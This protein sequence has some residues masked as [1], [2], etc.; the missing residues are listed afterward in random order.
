MK[1]AIITG[2]ALGA[3]V[4]STGLLTQTANAS[5]AYRTIKTKSYAGTTPAYHA[6]NL[7]KT[8]YM[9]NSTLTKKLHNLK[10]Y[11]R[12]TWYLQK[13]VKLSNG[14]KTGIFYY[15][16][17]NS[18]TASGYVWR[19]YLSKGINNNTDSNPTNTA[20]TI[21]NDTKLQAQMRSLFPGTKH[22]T[23]LDQLAHDDIS[24]NVS[25]DDTLAG[26]ARTA[27]NAPD[28][29]DV[30]VFRVTAGITKPSTLAKVKTV[31]ATN[32]TV[33][34]NDKTVSFNLAN[35][36]N[37]FNGYSIGSYIISTDPIE[38]VSATIILVK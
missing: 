15:L 37:A 27:V 20:A 35:K 5:A 23:A 3:F 11:H 17:N 36:F 18:N 14:K 24:D 9:W 30:Y 33:E 19:G 6:K 10:N 31:L 22:A 16:K 38:P 34:K 12:T 32:K 21:A 29:S 28:S 25:L 8:T 26:L 2:V 4:L 1:K 13:S 7:T